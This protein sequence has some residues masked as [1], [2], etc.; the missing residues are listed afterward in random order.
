MKRIIVMSLALLLAFC[1]LSSALPAAVAADVCED[2]AKGTFSGLSACITQNKG[3]HLCEKNF[4]DDRFRAAVA[5]SFDADKNG[6]LSEAEAA[7]AKKLDCSA[8]GVSDLKG[9]GYLAALEELDCSDNEIAV[10]DLEHN[11]SLRK[12]SA[13]GQAIALPYRPESRSVD[14]STV[15]GKDNCERIVAFG[16]Y[17]A[18]GG[19][20]SVSEAGGV[21]VFAASDPFYGFYLIT[22]GLSG[23]GLGLLTVRVY[24]YTDGEVGGLPARM[25]GGRLLICDKNFPDPALRSYLRTLASSDGVT[26]SAEK[27]AKTSLAFPGRGVADLTGLA[28][29][30]GIESLDC[31]S[32]AIESLNV[33][34]Y[35]GLKELN[36]SGNK[37]TSL[38]LGKKEKLEI[39]RCADNRLTSLDLSGCGALKALDCSGNN[40]AALDLSANKQLVA[41]DVKL[42]GQT[43]GT[44][45]CAK[46]QGAY[47]LD[48]SGYTGGH[49]TNIESVKAFTSAGADAGAEY[50]SATGVVRFR[51][52]P[53]RLTYR[54]YTASPVAGMPLLE[55]SAQTEASALT[56]VSGTFNG[57]DAWVLDGKLHLCDKNFP[58]EVFRKA[59][60]AFD[61]DGDGFLSEQEA[62]GVER[63]SLGGSGVASLKGIGYFTALEELLVPGN[64]LTELDLSANKAL[65]S[66]NCSGNR[67]TY[68]DLSDNAKLKAA[69]ATA[70]NQTGKP[71]TV[72]E[73][74]GK[75]TVSLTETVGAGRTKNV[76]AVSDRTGAAAAYDP[77]AGVAVFDKKPEGPLTYTYHTGLPTGPVTMNVTCEIRSDAPS[78]VHTSLTAVPAKA[79]TCTEDGNA[80]YFVCSCGKYF[81]DETALNE[82]AELRFVRFPALGHKP[83]AAYSA[84]ALFHWYACEREDCGVMVP[85]TKG[86]HFDA[87]KDGKCDACGSD[88]MSKGV[89][90]DVDGDGSLTPAD[91]RI[92]LRMSIKLETDATGSVRYVT[93]DAD[94]DGTVTP[95][96]A[97]QILRASV[98]LTDLRDFVV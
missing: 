38:L 42:S 17:D 14:V 80:A 69:H 67:L 18:K 22:T 49:G 40:L 92:A 77:A 86:A 93:A 34:G 19:E 35:P 50:A 5:E 90:G 4:P 21:A 84:S 96:D 28:F 53:A 61:K 97:R 9:I 30:G 89:L 60:T 11:M 15:I 95:E 82:I 68:L 16:G 33:D 3:L 2:C 66:L 79:A 83:A 52:E 37:L 72:K 85:A 26:L 91:A 8:R 25:A 78:H 29:F 51:S 55:V 47:L 87:D 56:C 20:I 81:T 32:N 44:L 98:E 13:E 76:T 23:E 12:L 41:A 10:A 71:L 64:A 94:L 36:C 27:L 1:L 73:T 75:F 45:G 70:G 43:L 59:L 58:D 62:A 46:V 31:S 65:S 88:R 57:V 7:S 6:E 24:P 63:L 48:L 54:Y 39:L 74:E